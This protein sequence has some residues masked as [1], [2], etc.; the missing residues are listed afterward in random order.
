MKLEYFG[1]IGRLKNKGKF[2]PFDYSKDIFV[3]NVIHQTLWQ[4]KEHVQ[5]LISYMNKENVNHEFRLIKRT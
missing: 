1:I 3:V 5:R 4:D 2:K